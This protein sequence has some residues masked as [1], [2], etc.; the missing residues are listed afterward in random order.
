M[1]SKLDHEKRDSL[2]RETYNSHLKKQKK[3]KKQL[4]SAFSCKNLAIKQALSKCLL[5]CRIVCQMRITAVWLLSKGIFFC[6]VWNASSHAFHNNTINLER[7][8]YISHKTNSKY[9]DTEETKLTKFQK[10]A[11]RLL[12]VAFYFGFTC[13]MLPLL[14]DN[15]QK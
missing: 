2:W 4:T 5:I 13:Y 3:Q 12:D 9:K 1:Y 7:C 6:S 14:Y 10:R 11:D 8:P 15:I